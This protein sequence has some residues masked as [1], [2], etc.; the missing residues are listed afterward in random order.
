MGPDQEYDVYFALLSPLVRLRMLQKVW[1]AITPKTWALKVIP[2]ADYEYFIRFALCCTS[3][4]LCCSYRI[5]RF[6]ITIIQKIPGRDPLN[7]SAT[8][9]T[10]HFISKLTPL[11]YVLL[12]AERKTASELPYSKPM[13]LCYSMKMMTYS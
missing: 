1:I 5:F 13:E 6:L 3:A 2:P 7:E 12:I 9:E 10:G 4:E 11:C 8:I